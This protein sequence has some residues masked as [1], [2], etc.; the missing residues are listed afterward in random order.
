MISWETGKIML[1]GWGVFSTWF[2]TYTA[3]NVLKSKAIFLSQSKKIQEDYSPFYRHD[4]KN[5]SL[6][7]SIFFAVFYIPFVGTTVLTWL[8]IT[9]LSTLILTAAD[10]LDK[11]ISK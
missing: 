8:L 2:C 6:L 9:G 1:V 4:V 7:R 5:W 3:Y 11:P 10:D